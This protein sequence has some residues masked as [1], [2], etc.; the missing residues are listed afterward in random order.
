MEGWLASGKCC[1]TDRVGRKRRFAMSW[2]NRPWKI[3]MLLQIVT[4]V[5]GMVVCT[6]V[7]ALLPNRLQDAIKTTIHEAEVSAAEVAISGV[8]KLLSQHG[9][10]VASPQEATNMPVLGSPAPVM[11]S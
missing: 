1:T 4:P 11:G 3:K 9:V 10:I 6:L 5:I 7:G 2:L 8:A